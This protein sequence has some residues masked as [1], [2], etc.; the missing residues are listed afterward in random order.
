MKGAN[1][2]I[3]TGITAKSVPIETDAAVAT[4]GATDHISHVTLLGLVWPLNIERM[5]ARAA[6]SEK[7]A[8]TNTVN[9]NIHF[10]P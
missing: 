2:A 1:P 7:A 10:S 6:S 3:N 5:Y 4:K 9:S 8:A